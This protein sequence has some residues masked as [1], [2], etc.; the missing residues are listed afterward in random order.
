MRANTGLAHRPNVPLRGAPELPIYAGLPRRVADRTASFH[1][2]WCRTAGDAETQEPMSRPRGG[3]QACRLSCRSVVGKEHVRAVVAFLTNDF[4]AFGAVSGW[5]SPRRAFSTPGPTDKPSSDRQQ[6]RTTR[7]DVRCAFVSISGPGVGRSRSV[8]LRPPV[9]PS[10]LDMSRSVSARDIHGGAACA[11]PR[12]PAERSSVC[13]FGVLSGVHLPPGANRRS[14]SMI[15]GG[16]VYATRSGNPF[17]KG[18]VLRDH[19]LAPFKP[20][21]PRRRRPVGGGPRHRGIRR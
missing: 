20:A 21:G 19:Y 15:R 10:R 11:S 9:A 1:V 14:T 6:H 13:S 5:S 3:R 17:P 18:I 2:R 7:C 16:S 8:A 12:A 4:A